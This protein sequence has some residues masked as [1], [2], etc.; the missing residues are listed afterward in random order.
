MRVH[1]YIGFV[2]TKKKTSIGT[3][4]AYIFSLTRISA[5]QGRSRM[6]EGRDQDTHIRNVYAARGRE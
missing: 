6:L 1:A 5:Q 2:D 3:S 4:C